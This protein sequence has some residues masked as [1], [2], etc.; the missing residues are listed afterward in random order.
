MH[1]FFMRCDMHLWRRGCLPDFVEKIHFSYTCPEDHLPLPLPHGH[2]VRADPGVG[3]PNNC[4][5]P[6]QLEDVQMVDRWQLTSA[7]HWK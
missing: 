7:Y 2:V 1:G 3:N 6:S 4:S 5:K